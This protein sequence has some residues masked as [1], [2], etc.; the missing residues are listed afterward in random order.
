M[1]RPLFAAALALPLAFAASAV[2]LSAQSIAD[3]GA[4]IAPQFNSYN[5][6]SPSNTKI[7]EFSV[8]LFALVPITPSFS[9]DVGTAWVQSRVT[10]TGT[11]ATT[12][13]DISGL[14]DTQVRANYTLGNDFVVLT[15]GVNLPT[16]K[17]TVTAREQLA[18]SLIG[19]DFLA[20]PI[21]NM[22]T[23]FGFTG[24]LAIARPLGDW[25]A[26]GGV[27]VRR[28]SQY[29]PFDAAGGTALHYQPGNEY[30]ARLGVDRA[31]G[32]GRIALGFTYSK[33]GDDNLGGSIYNTGDRYLATLGL[34]NTVGGG[35][36]TLSGWNLFRSSGTIAGGTILG[37]EN[38]SDA[39]LSY[40][41]NLGSMVLE[42]NV[43]GR[44]WI[45]S[46]GLPSSLMTT[47]G[48]RSQ[49]TWIGFSVLPSVGYSLG[50]VATQDLNGANTT[51]QLTG[52][53]ATLG[54]RVH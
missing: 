8:P 30:R 36:L 42:P 28:S 53:H 39:A 52:W 25:N 29:D 2:P 23:G 50:R 13:S 33:F 3:A 26:G 49:M 34:D 45:Q 16:G 9:L 37:H 18:A 19:S 40:G 20:F 6:Q 4:R 11:G 7:S 12:T 44:T 48:L 43:E 10:Q 41:M 35:T 54:V 14:T 24:G 22:G 27:S 47:L 31:V 5:L 1:I 15:G 46:N 21:S 32:T 38:I 17:S 51:A